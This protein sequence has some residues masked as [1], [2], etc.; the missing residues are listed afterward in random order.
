[1]KVICG[2]CQIVITEGPA[3]PVSHGLCT[4]CCAKWN[5]DIDALEAAK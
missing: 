4:S 5:A 1:M 2:W 3:K